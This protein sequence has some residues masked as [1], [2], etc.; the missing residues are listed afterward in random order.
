MLLT[1]LWRVAAQELLSHFMVDNTEAQR[2]QDKLTL[3]RLQSEGARTSE[4]Y[5][6][7]T[8]MMADTE[9]RKV[10]L[11]LQSSNY[12][13][14][15]DYFANLSCAIYSRQGGFRDW[16]RGGKRKRKRVICH[17]S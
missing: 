15:S 12:V 2:H 9:E 4:K 13:R 6:E 10:I 8:E 11:S 3:L 5:L 14:P 1:A 16:V 7:V 17:F